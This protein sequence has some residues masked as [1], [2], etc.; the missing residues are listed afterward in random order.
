TCM[1]F[2]QAMLLLGYTYAHLT[3]SWLGVRLQALVHLVLLFVP[4]VALPITVH[5]ELAP[6]GAA[7]PALGVLLLLFVMSGLP[8]FVL[9]TSA[10]LLQKW[11][12]DTGH[13]EAH[14]PYFLYGASNLGSMLALLGY[15][16]LLEQNQ[17]LPGQSKLW[18]IG[19]F[20]LAMLTA[21]CAVLL[22][23][24]PRASA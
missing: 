17:P 10:P 23:L 8:F 13:P 12:A 15:P 22:W 3:T 24:S 16:A 5:A 4:I 14:D 1:V 11:F 18:M 21:L 20:A 6:Q 2:F 7:N 9:A 19:Y